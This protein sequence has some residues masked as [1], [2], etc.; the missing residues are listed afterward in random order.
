[1]TVCVVVV[2][3][4]ALFWHV[5]VYYDVFTHTHSYAQKVNRRSC[6][7][8]LVC[9]LSDLDPL[10]TPISCSVVLLPYHGFS[11]RFHTYLNVL[12]ERTCISECDGVM[13]ITTANLLAALRKVSYVKDGVP[14]PLRE[15]IFGSTNPTEIVVATTQVPSFDDDIENPTYGYRS[16]G[17]LSFVDVHPDFPPAAFDPHW[18]LL[19]VHSNGNAKTDLF[20][21]TWRH[22]GLNLESHFILIFTNTSLPLPLPSPSPAHT[23]NASPFT[24][25]TFSNPSHNGSYHSSRGFQT[26]PVPNNGSSSDFRRGMCSPFISP[27]VAHCPV[28][29]SYNQVCYQPASLLAHNERNNRMSSESGHSGIGM[30][31]PFILPSMAHCRSRNW[32]RTLQS[33]IHAPLT[34][35]CLR[36]PNFAVTLQYRN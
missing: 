14:L 32:T 12:I 24:H 29:G 34:Y 23:R 7:F 21:W 5:F 27:S 13:L 26:P 9:H 3:G 15:I 10:T 2:P 19:A 35:C 8:F 4:L 33:I 11:M 22:C 6:D 18:D 25:D 31:F 36:P 16:L 28:T 17:L 20:Y 30:H 1:M